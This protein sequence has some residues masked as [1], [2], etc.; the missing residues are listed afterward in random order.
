MNATH[1]DIN[2]LS[3]HAKTLAIIRQAIIC[4]RAEGCDPRQ[5]A[6]LLDEA[7]DTQIVRLETRITTSG[8]KFPFEQFQQGIIG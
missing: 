5:V 6:D 2:A 4:L 7:V 3:D 1:E 8:A